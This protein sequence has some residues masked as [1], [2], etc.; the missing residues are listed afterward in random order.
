MPQLSLSN[1]HISVT[2]VP[3]FGARVTEL[4]DRRSGRNWLIGGACEGDTGEA[5]GYAGREA[6]GWDECVPTVAPCQ[7]P[8]RGRRLRDHGDLWGRPWHGAQQGDA[9]VCRFDGPEFTFT[10]RLRLEGPR[11]FCEYTITATTNVRLPWMWSQHVLLATRPGERIVLDGV[12]DWAAYGPE[13]GVCEV[14]GLEAGVVRKCYGAVPEQAS[15]GI[16]G[17]DGGIRL[18]W[19]GAETPFCGLWVAFG[20]WPSPEAPVHQTALEPT[21]SRN[22]AALLIR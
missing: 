12:Q 22:R 9:L 10:R 8:D 14:L 5:A 11:L 19:S 3:E 1:D 15:V 17:V 6:R 2:V 7:D 21:T 4:M 16:D 13:P 18:R 20:D